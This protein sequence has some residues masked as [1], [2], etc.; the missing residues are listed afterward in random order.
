MGSRPRDR[1]VGE[2]RGGGE[3]TPSG[4]S[5]SALFDPSVVDL[6]SS[7]ELE[8]IQ[9]VLGTVLVKL[10]DGEQLELLDQEGA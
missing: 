10:V 4:V 8:D 2:S 5:V 7:G 6:G 3:A 9:S 1:Q